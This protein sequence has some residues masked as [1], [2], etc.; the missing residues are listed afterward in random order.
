MKEIAVKFKVANSQIRFSTYPLQ[1]K[2]RKPIDII[3]AKP[4][5][6]H[7]QAGKT[8][9]TINPRSHGEECLKSPLAKEIKKTL[10]D[11]PEA[12]MLE[13]RG[14]LILA[15]EARYD[16]TK[17][18]LT[19]IFDDLES[20]GMADGATSDTVISQVQK[21]LLGDKEFHLVSPDEFPEQ[22]KIARFK[23][24]ILVGLTDR[25]M[26]AKIVQGRNSSRN[27]KGWSMSD[28]RGEY[29]WIKDILEAPNSR[30]KDKVGYDENAGKNLD[31]L[32]IISYLN[33][34]HPAYNNSND[35]ESL[36]PT[37]S[38]SGKGRL[39]QIM[40]R[41]DMKE[42]FRQ[43][44]P[45]L[46][47]ILDLHDYV[48]SNFE[49]AYETAYD[50]K[51]RLGK[52]LEIKSKGNGKPW[53]LPLT[54]TPT[55]YMIPAGLLYPLLSSLR[56]LI[57]FGKRKDSTPKW[58]EDPKAF[59]DKHGPVLVKRLFRLLQSAGSQNK[60]GKDPETYRNMLL[61]GKNC[62]QEDSENQ[63]VAA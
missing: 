51:A 18:E 37:A 23:M 40:E 32:D 47:S 54:E 20:H 15:K 43:L 46:P 61:E 30:F 50:G 5:L 59:F 35:D 13:N 42:G 27:V 39:N 45:L 36:A 48:Y 21:E 56:A 24:E 33:L 25:D 19:L 22:F 10:L 2:R 17:E 44:A 62:L 4:F 11:D 8:P 55:N 3:E 60:L 16:K 26:I 49:R 7:Y 53:L 34:F 29:D 12:F 52:R 9:N 57:D 6:C 31:A 63:L 41:E 58:K 1:D 38:Y 14:C 28:F